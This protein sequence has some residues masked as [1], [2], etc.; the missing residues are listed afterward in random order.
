[1]KIYTKTG[2]KGETSLIGGTRVS[3]SH[4]R[5]EAYGTLDELNA[6]VGLLVAKIEALHQPPLTSQLKCLKEIQHK[7]FNSGSYLAC[8]DPALQKQLPTLE[9]SFVSEL[10]NQMDEMSEEVVVLSQFILPGGHETSGLAH[11]ARTVARRA[12][13]H[14]SRLKE[15]EGNVS[16]VVIQFI[17]RLSDY[18][19]VLARYLNHIHQIDDVIWK[20]SNL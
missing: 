12:E 2:D 20:K 18:F 10:E 14:I 16:E 1:M 8:E 6:L 13:R 7:L 4:L 17:N 5:L 19:F 15:Q 3:K 9:P 11:I